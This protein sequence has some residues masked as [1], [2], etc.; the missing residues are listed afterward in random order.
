MRD[1]MIFYASFQEAIACLPDEEQLALYKAIINYGL[2][3][4]EPVISGAALGMFLLMKPQI[5]ANNRRFEAGK[6]GGKP[7]QGV[8]AEATEAGNDRQSIMVKNQEETKPEPKWNQEQTKPEPKHNQTQ[9]KGKPNVNVN[10][11][12][13]VNDNVNNNAND[14]VKRKIFRPPTA[15]EVKAYC[16]E[17]GICIDAQAFVDFY[18]SKG[19][20]VGKNKMK[21]WKAAA[22]NWGRNEKIQKKDTVQYSQNRFNNFHQRE[23]DFDELEKRLLT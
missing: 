17:Q 9:T 11:N 10:D 5:E 16:Q 6:R 12:E 13:N 8:T 19:W 4:I 1:S 2:K 20:M 15:D 3:G 23:Y 21:D 14:N 22:R 7:R 18:E